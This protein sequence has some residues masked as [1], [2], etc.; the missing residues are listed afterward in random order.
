MSNKIIDLS[1][2]KKEQKQFLEHLES[3]NN[4]KYQ[5]AE[6]NVL[7]WII[8]AL[9]SE[10]SEVLNASKI[11]KIW[12][13][14]EVN[15]EHLV[16]ELADLMAHIGNLSN[17]INENL[18][19]TV[20]EIQVTAVETTFNR[21]AYWITTLKWNKRHARNTLKSYMLP[22]FIELVYSFGFDMDELEVA[23]KE[24]M[25]KNYERFA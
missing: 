19:L 11:H 22:G 1:Y 23:Y 17:M 15:R 25:K 2:V 10:L 13:K 9:Q 4:I 21:L 5:D 20:E 16:E 6:F 8:L 7:Y 3:I 24:K 14:E 18:V 12:S